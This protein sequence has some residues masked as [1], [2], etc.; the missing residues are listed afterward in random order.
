MQSELQEVME[1]KASAVTQEQKAVQDRLQQVG[2]KLSLDQ[3]GMCFSQ[4]LRLS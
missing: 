4:L 1:R 3:I 2:L